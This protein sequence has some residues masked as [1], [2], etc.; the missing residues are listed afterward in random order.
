MC[1]LYPPSQSDIYLFTTASWPTWSPT[2]LL[3][4]SKTAW[5]WRRPLISMWFSVSPTER[6]PIVCY[7]VCGMNKLIFGDWYWDRPKTDMNN[8]KISALRPKPTTSLVYFMAEFPWSM[9]V[10][11]IPDLNWPLLSPLLILYRCRYYQPVCDWANNVKRC[12]TSCSIVV[13]KIWSRGSVSNIKR[14]ITSGFVA[15]DKI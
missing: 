2:Y 12:I 13:H 7:R 10:N 1:S 11:M 14:F 9:K 8:N 4:R 15:I 3:A 6:R 5:T